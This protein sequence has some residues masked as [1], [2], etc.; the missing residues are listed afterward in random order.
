MVMRTVVFLIDGAYGE[1]EY[2]KT[3]RVRGWGVRK[4][5]PLTLVVEIEE[6][7]L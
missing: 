5:H 3:Y 4:W 2:D 6:V 7:I 1:P